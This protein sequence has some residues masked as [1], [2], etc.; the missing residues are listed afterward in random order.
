MLSFARNIFI[1]P[2]RNRVYTTVWLHNFD[3]TKHLQEK[4]DENYT[5]MLRA[6]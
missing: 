6:V 2:S 5:K 1:L 3:F 4:L